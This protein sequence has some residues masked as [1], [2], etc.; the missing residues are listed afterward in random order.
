MAEAFLNAMAPDLFEAESAGIEPGKL[1]PVVVDAMKDAGIDISS[2]KTKSVHDFIKEGR[3]YDFVITVCDEASSE[4][5]PVFPG[6][7][8]RL[9]MGFSDPSAFSG[10]YEEK[11]RKTRTVRDQIK[12][13]LQQWIE[14][15][16]TF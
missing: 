1:N 5:C 13:R 10:N 16:E 7:G 14:K 12:A 2:N 4:R 8:R 3:A 11:L 9:H 6:G 15:V